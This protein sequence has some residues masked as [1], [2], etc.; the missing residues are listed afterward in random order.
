[1]QGPITALRYGRVTKRATLD[2]LEQ[3]VASSMS[4]ALDGVSS[5]ICAFIP[6]VENMQAAA[7]GL[8]SFVYTTSEPSAERST[9]GRPTEPLS[10]S[11]LMPAAMQSIHGLSRF[12]AEAWH[13]IIAGL[14]D[15]YRQTVEVATTRGAHA[16]AYE[17]AWTTLYRLELDIIARNPGSTWDAPEHRAMEGVKTKIGQPP[18][19]AD[20]RFQVEAYILSLEVRFMLAQ[21][22]T[23][24]VEALRLSAAS[25]EAVKHYRLW[26]SFVEFVLNSCSADARKAVGIAR[27][28]SAS[29][30]LARCTVYVIRSVFELF[31]IRLLEERGRLLRLG[32]YAQPERH[33]LANTVRINATKMETALEKH[34][35]EYIRSRPSQNMEE[36]KKEGIWFQDNCA[37]KVHCWLQE[38]K[39][40]EEYLLVDSPYQLLSLQEKED[41][42]RAFNF[43]HRGHF[44]NCENGHTFVITECGG[45]TQ[46][47]RCPECNAPIGGSDHQLQ[48]SNTRATGFETIAGQQ[49]ALPGAWGWTRDA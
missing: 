30:Q 29:R 42:V 18:Y 41:I 17:A 44:Y 20:T 47:A 25:Q 9:E 8:R 28:S 24:R 14:E 13:T 22:A 3:N 45:A 27:K 21:I 6:Q 32:F 35:Q 37:R 10:P 46:S 33:N 11:L 36:L 2:I 26:L 5:R 34:R 4:H 49:G 31:R 38:C 23:S 12:E 40:L 39:Q 19:K 7:S 43:S 48:A 1:M 16:K 15:V